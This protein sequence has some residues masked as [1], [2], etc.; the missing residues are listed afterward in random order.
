MSID[1]ILICRILFISNMNTPSSKNINFCYLAF[2]EKLS[3]LFKDGVEL[4]KKEYTCFSTQSLTY[5]NKRYEI[6]N[7]IS[8]IPF[9]IC[10]FIIDKLGVRQ[11]EVTYRDL[12]N[13][14]TGDYLKIF[15]EMFGKHI[16]CYKIGD[17]EEYLISKNIIYYSLKPCV[18][19]II[20]SIF[21]EISQRDSLPKVHESMFGSQG[22]KYYDEESSDYT[23]GHY[24]P[25]LDLDQ[26]DPD[27][28]DNLYD[29]D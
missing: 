22:A 21:F 20:D 9:L 7:S 28:Y 2:N 24:N 16:S 14:P 18:I 6:Y 15:I 29:D 26:Q 3:I 17:K 4:E 19:K 1:T 23:E 13:V 10:E 5:K 25:D 8:N 27:Y 11:Q 12:E